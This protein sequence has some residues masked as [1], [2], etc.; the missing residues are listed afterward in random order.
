[1][2]T[3][4]TV[5]VSG[6]MIAATLD[7]GQTNAHRK[8]QEAWRDHPRFKRKRH[9]RV[10]IKEFADYWGYDLKEFVDQIN[11]KCKMNIEYV[12]G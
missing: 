3:P 11:L 2:N 7:T 9:A 4:G 5:Y 10:T 8:I 12:T 1:M 6:K